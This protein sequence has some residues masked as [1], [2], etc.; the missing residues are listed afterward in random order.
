VFYGGWGKSAASIIAENI[1]KYEKI[2]FL[3]IVF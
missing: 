1:K 3:L 2:S